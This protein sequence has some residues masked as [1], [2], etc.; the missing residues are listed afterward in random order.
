M[1]PVYNYLYWLH[2]V[3]PLLNSLPEKRLGL[4]KTLSYSWYSVGQFLK[5]V[6][7]APFVKNG[8][9]RFG[10][11]C[12]T[13][14]DSKDFFWS[15][16]AEIVEKV[17]YIDDVVQFSKAHSTHFHSSLSQIVEYAL[18]GF[19][20]NRII[21]GTKEDRDR[22][23]MGMPGGGGNFLDNLMRGFGRPPPQMR[24]EEQREP[25]A[26]QIAS[27]VAMGFTESEARV[28]LR[29]NRLNTD[30]SIEELINNRAHYT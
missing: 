24:E 28:S 23:D 15:I 11:V 30:I 12:K 3:T 27:I 16:N 19:A 2:K 14:A 29:E 4:A 18:K 26:A 22:F 25:T 1:R 13:F 9:E 20:H 8:R 7:A 21:T 17:F 6:M 5:T 10:L